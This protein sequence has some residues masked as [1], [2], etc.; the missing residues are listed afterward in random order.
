MLEAFLQRLL[1]DGI[2]PDTRWLQGGVPRELE[3]D[4][5]EVRAEVKQMAAN[6][7]F[8]L[9]V[10]DDVRRA[11]ADQPQRPGEVVAWIEPLGGLPLRLTL[12]ASLNEAVRRLQKVLFGTPFYQIGIEFEGKPVA[13]LRTIHYFAEIA[14]EKTLREFFAEA[15]VR[16]ILDARSP[17]VKKVR[18][19]YRNRAFAMPP[20]RALPR[21]AWMALNNPGRHQDVEVVG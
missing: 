1:D 7:L 12:R 17:T 20:H 16:K 9:S 5:A 4:W 6:D 14:D 3:E 2:E 19:H 11:V 21:I 10:W 15:W 18:F 13:N 8:A